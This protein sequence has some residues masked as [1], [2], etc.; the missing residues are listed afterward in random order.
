MHGGIPPEELVGRSPVLATA[1]P[2]AVTDLLLALAGMWADRMHR[3]TRAPTLRR[4]QRR[5]HDAALSWGAR[6]VTAGHTGRR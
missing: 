6:R 4:F 1:D 5:F 3:R 2:A